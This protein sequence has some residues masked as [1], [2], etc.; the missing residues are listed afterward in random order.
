MQPRLGTEAYATW[1]QPP[2][3]RHKRLPALQHPFPLMPPHYHHSAREPA[4]DEPFAFAFGPG[5]PSPSAAMPAKHRATT[6]A[7]TTKP[8]RLG[9][10]GS[11]SRPR[12]QCHS[13]SPC[14]WPLDYTPTA[15]SPS[16]NLPYSLI[17]VP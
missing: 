9:T 6:H 17:C 15:W 11:T 3:Y 14:F 1:P 12:E 16:S 10:R 7:S 4:R 8:H 5:P 13:I 2:R